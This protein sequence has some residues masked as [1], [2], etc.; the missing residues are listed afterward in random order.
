MLISNT[1]R[2]ATLRDI[3]DL[4]AMP[5]GPDPAHDE[6]SGEPLSKSNPE[7]TAV[8]ARLTAVGLEHGPEAWEEDVA[9]QNEGRP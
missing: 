4:D 3:V 6:D 8:A 9:H 2:R 1:L 7:G 5:D